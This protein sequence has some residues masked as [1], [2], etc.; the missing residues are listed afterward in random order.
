[1]GDH[2]Q[3]SYGHGGDRAGYDYN[4]R[5]YE[6]EREPNNYHDQRPNGGYTFRGAA[7]RQSYQPPQDFTFRASGPSAPR[8]PPSD[9]YASQAQ[10][11]SRSRRADQRQRS[12]RRPPPYDGAPARRGRGG[13]RGRGRPAHTR[14]ILQNTRRETTPEQLEG[15]NSEGQVRFKEAESSSDEADAKIIDLTHEDEEDDHDATA[16]RK[17]TKLDAP[18]ESAAPRWSNPDPYT[19]LPPPETLGAPKKDIVQV[20]RKAKMDSSAKSDDKNAA[21]ENDFISLNFDDDFDEDDVDDVDDESMPV[22]HQPLPAVPPRSSRLSMTSGHLHH[23][24]TTRPEACL[25]HH[26]AS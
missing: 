5:G 3:P 8:F 13:F 16:P 15:M 18:A 7:D 22:L 12:D 6:R 24:L 23:H 4:Y 10:P 20:I 19:V 1:M 2:Y 11:Q 25:L 14:D 9:P 17:R 26:L 21:K